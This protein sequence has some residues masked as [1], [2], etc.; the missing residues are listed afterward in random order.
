M[1]EPRNR[2]PTRANRSGLSV[3]SRRTLPTR[4]ACTVR[5]RAASSAAVARA[6][7]AAESMMS[8]GAWYA[9]FEQ[10]DDD[11]VLRLLQAATD[12]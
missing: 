4:A 11:E 10:V 1:D 9:Q 8:V 2:A 12:R 7:V 5:L 3:A 6:V